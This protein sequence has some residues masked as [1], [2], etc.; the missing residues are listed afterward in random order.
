MI[1]YILITIILA[2]IVFFMTMKFN[3]YLRLFVVI[4][5]IITAVLMLMFLI[6][7]IDKLPE[8]SRNITRE[9]INSWGRK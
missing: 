6:R 2:I 3:I 8:G 1:I 9:E 4:S 5:F 7:N